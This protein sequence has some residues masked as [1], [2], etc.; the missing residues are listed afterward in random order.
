MNPNDP[1]SRL[2]PRFR[3]IAP[4]YP[5]EFPNEPL[6]TQ[7]SGLTPLPGWDR[8][9]VR[10]ADERLV[11]IRTGQPLRNQ[12][13]DQPGAVPIEGMPGSSTVVSRRGGGGLSFGKQTRHRF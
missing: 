7:Q 9:S 6:A 11:S 2:V 12:G 3:D 8:S 10:D 4:L 13:P 5:D 1:L